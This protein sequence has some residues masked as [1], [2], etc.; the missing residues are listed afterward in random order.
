[1]DTLTP[2]LNAL[3]L[4]VPL[5]EVPP[6]VLRV[7]KSRVLL[8]LVIHAFQRGE[9]PEGIAQSYDTRILLTHDRESVP[10]FAYDR[11]N[12]GEAMPGVCCGSA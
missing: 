7:G 4:P 8:A 10:G 3:T 6:G 5:Y 9:T 1:M 2:E 12:A 11:V